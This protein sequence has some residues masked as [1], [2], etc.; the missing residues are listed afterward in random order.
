MEVVCSFQICYQRYHC[1]VIKL[2]FFFSK[3]DNF[4]AT[5]AAGD[6]AAHAEE[7]KILKYRG[8][9][10]THSFVPVAIETTGVIG[11][12]SLQFLKELGRR[13]CRQTS[14]PNS[15]SYL[16][17]APLNCHPERKLSFS[18]GGVSGV[19]FKSFSPQLLFFYYSYYYYLFIYSFFL[20]YYHFILLS[21]CNFRPFAW[22]GLYFYCLCIVII[23]IS[24]KKIFF[25]NCYV[26]FTHSYT[27]YFYIEEL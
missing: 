3:I 20:I 23:C 5:T 10:V 12:W 25:L 4:Q 2:Q 9:P 1:S 26:F 15:T 11:A 21:F 18:H 17:T 13:V 19:V 22:P 24:L 27:D 16:L 14:D 6:V 7:R 8:L